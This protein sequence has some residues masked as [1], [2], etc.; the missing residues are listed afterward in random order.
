[1]L[2]K[3]SRGSGIPHPVDIHIGDRLRQR[4]NECG[5]SQGKL[6]ELIDITFQQIQKY[7]KGTN[8]ISGSRLWEL[9]EALDTCVQYFYEGYVSNQKRKNHHDSRY[10]RGGRTCFILLITGSLGNN[11][12]LS[13]SSVLSIKHLAV[14]RV[15]A[16]KKKK[17]R[18]KFETDC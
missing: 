5:F 2:K 13:N 7:E 17:I 18:S 12:P 10:Q 11:Q 9:A 16:D 15:Q 4:R 1:M 3:Y 6:A 14:G 8:R